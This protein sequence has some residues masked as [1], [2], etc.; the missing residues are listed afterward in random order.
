MISISNK[1]RMI[2]YLLI[3]LAVFAV[4]SYAWYG[5]EMIMYGSSQ[6]SDIDTIFAFWFSFRFKRK[7]KNK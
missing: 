1:T 7:M 4:I 2:E 6:A 3:L 5:A